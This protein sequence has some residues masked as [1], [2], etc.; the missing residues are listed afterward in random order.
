MKRLLVVP[1]RTSQTPDEAV[2]GAPDL[3]TPRDYDLVEI[4]VVF[5]G[6]INESLRLQSMW[7]AYSENVEIGGPA[8]GADGGDRFE[9]GRFVKKG[10]VHTSRGC[11]HRCPF[12]YVWRR[13]G[14]IRELP[15]T[16]GNILQDNN[17]LAC[18]EAHQERVFEMLAGQKQVRF[19]GGLDGCYITR[20]KAEMIARLKPLDVWTANDGQREKLS[21]RGIHLLREAGLSQDKVRCYVLIG[22]DETM[23]AATARLNRT[24]M[25]GAMPFAQLYDGVGANG[26]RLKAWKRLAREWSRPAI[27]RTKI[28]ALRGKEGE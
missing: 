15:I 4:S 26:E 7:L 14:G 12:C 22:F 17:I 2:V 21:L 8:F 23:E 11:P 1:R 16:E 24:L 28:T 20:R 25:A 3:F 13:E 27:I 9:P 5:T 6:D 10:I 18:S 19:L